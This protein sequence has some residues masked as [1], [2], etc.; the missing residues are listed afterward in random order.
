[1]FFQKVLFIS[2]LGFI[3]FS[4]NAQKISFSSDTEKFPKELSVFMEKSNKRKQATQFR[5][6]FTAFWHSDIDNSTQKLIIETCNLLL[7]KKA[8]AYPNFH[9]YFNLVFDFWKKDKANFK[10]WQQGFFSQIKNKQ[11]R[12]HK[13]DL[14]IHQTRKL[15]YDSIL[16]QSHLTTWKITTPKYKYQF[17]Y[18]E[19]SIKFEET[20]LQTIS[21]YDT[22]TIHNTSGTYFPLKKIWLGNKGRVNWLPTKNTPKQYV[23]FKDYHIDIL[24]TVYTVDTVTFH[25]KNLLE[26]NIKGKFTNKNNFIKNKNKL[27]YP[28]FESFD[29]NIVIEKL[30]P[31]IHYKGGIIIH[32]NRLLGK[33]SQKNPAKIELLRNDSLLF[34][35]T[36][37]IFAF[38]NQQIVSKLAKID[39]KID[40]CRFYHPGLFFRY[41]T[42]LKQ[43]NLL[44]SNN[45]IT[46]SPFFDTY[47]N[48][49]F[50][51]DKLTWNINSNKIFFGDNKIS[52][53]PAPRVESIHF[54]SMKRF[55]Q[56]Q[57]M[58]STNPLVLLHKY[59]QYTYSN[60]FDANDYAN[61]IKKPI[62]Q[63]K[64]QLV[65]L[66][67]QGFLDYN[68]N[69]QEVTLF[70][71]VSSYIRSAMGKQDYDVIRFDTEPN[72]KKFDAILNLKDNNI[73]L[74][75]IRKILVSDSQKVA[76]Y[77]HSKQVMV[78]R[79]R[80]FNFDGKIEAG[81]LDMFGN[82]FD[83]SYDKFKINF[84]Q[85]DSIQLYTPMESKY[86]TGLR[87]VKKVSSVLEKISG[88]L[89]IDDT[90]NKSGIKDFPEYSIFNSSDSCFVF[91]DSKH[92]RNGIYKRDTFYFKVAPF[93]IKNTNKLEQTDIQLKGKLFSGGIFPNIPNTLIPQKDNSLGFTYTTPIKGLPIYNKGI[94]TDTITLSGSG[95][96]GKGTLSYLGTN[97]KSNFF[98]FLPKKTIAQNAEFIGLS[99]HYPDIKG[100]ALS[101]EWIPEADKTTVKTS[102]KPIILYH[103]NTSFTGTLNLTPSSVIGS[104]KVKLFSSQLKSQHF[105]FK[106]DSIKADTANLK[107]FKADSI[108][109][110]FESKSINGTINMTNKIAK[111]SNNNKDNIS[112]FWVAKFKGKTNK[113]TWNVEKNTIN[114]QNTSSEYLSELWQNKQI[115]LLPDSLQN[116]FIAANPQQDSLTIKTP[117]A[118]YNLNT[119]IIAAKYVHKV[120]IADALVFPK[121][122]NINIG[123]RGVIDTLEN[124]EIVM[125][126][127]V[128]KYKIYDAK[129]VLKGRNKFSGSGKYDYL[130]ENNQ[131]QLVTIDSLTVD[132]M[133][134]AA[135]YGKI[136]STQNFWLNQ[137][138]KYYGNIK[139]TGKDTL[140]QFNGYTLI[141]NS[142]DT[143]SNYWVGFSQNINSKNALIP[144]DS[145][146]RD[147]K[148][149]RLF[150]AFYLTNDSIHI[151]A[152]FLGHR[153]FYTDNPLLS[154]EGY[155]SYNKNINAYE[156]GNIKKLEQNLLPG[157]IIRFY[158]DKCLIQGQGKLNL[159]CTLGQIKQIA[160]GTIEHNSAQNKTS[161]NLCY[162]VDFGFNEEALKIMQNIFRQ[163]KLP[164]ISAKDINIQQKLTE[165][166]GREATLKLLLQ[167]KNLKQ[168]MLPLPLQRTF[169]FN[170]LNFVWHNKKK[171]YIS[172][173]KIGI[174][175]IKNMQLNKEVTGKIEL[176]KKR[177]GNRL[178]IYLELDKQTWF[179]FEYFHGVM[180]V[181]SSDTKFNNIIHKTKER[182]RRFKGEDKRIPYSYILTTE[183]KKD[184]FLKQVNN[185]R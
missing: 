99:K 7:Q 81:L 10:I 87:K 44:R 30:F 123:V 129:V 22:I 55:M 20:D 36:S 15:V 160:S 9:N 104:G 52:N 4:T 61:F 147:N 56:I 115:N 119:G 174:G 135:A 154:A 95:L 96:C 126:T 83:F 13:M 153:K 155:L 130:N 58:D 134:Q 32:G 183:S 93:A 94:F 76:I 34:T 108:N 25:N 167:Q 114:F 120:N 131:K 31:N 151:Y 169:F 69:T 77:P 47:H 148:N 172:E 170:N 41:N 117:L 74:N 60:I 182:K 91:Y 86:K 180:F 156:I 85:L 73:K 105:K 88:N 35:A 27:K 165:I 142:C 51:T 173:G 21:K 100:E 181:C 84:N 8:R 23:T 5:E 98:I 45:S 136:D 141:N 54:F 50:N 71:R 64:Q 37:K 17:L 3:A 11:L 68:T 137:Y 49:I 164:T 97:T 171:S 33:G 57:G 14:F 109:P 24:K 18:N 118:V 65:N 78:K 59:A 72:I 176:N 149:T 89:L 12:I 175:N 122:G 67:F 157:N 139:I 79:N 166:L 19:L 158:S 179:F 26:T 82:N 143:R 40:T 6:K 102:T 124:A 145:T 110:V 66:S 178:T 106:R 125:D 42:K 127:I 29:N 53:K 140:P 185:E 38:N 144:V 168:M 163:K 111:F 16:H 128:Q 162:G 70:P 1:M 75:G 133:K 63:V 103:D 150:N 146:T 28:R 46:K 177:S 161:L 113:F 39:L 101:V 159:G 116:T 62:N 92:I 138:F 152:S 107:I 43:L 90:H 48:I 80:D 132:T 112:D 184:D 2:L 121:N